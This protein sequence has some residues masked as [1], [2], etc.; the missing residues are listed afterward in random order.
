MRHR[1]GESFEVGKASSLLHAVEET[2]TSRFIR[3]PALFLFSLIFLITDMYSCISSLGVLSGKKMSKGKSGTV[4]KALLGSLCEPP[5][6]MCLGRRRQIGEVESNSRQA[7]LICCCWFDPPQLPRRKKRNTASHEAARGAVGVPVDLALDVHRRC[8]GENRAAAS[9]PLRQQRR[10]SA[11]T[12][13]MA[14]S[15]G[16]TLTSVRPVTPAPL[17]R[18]LHSLFPATCDGAG[19]AAAS[20]FDILQMATVAT[21]SGGARQR[22]TWWHTS[23]R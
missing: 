1:K 5:A 11:A 18:S 21:Y 20:T 10:G 16:G 15:L 9:F 7:S 19:A 22:A 8:K 6:Q 13:K 3:L 14:D 4:A 12:A 23:F 17:P 2:S